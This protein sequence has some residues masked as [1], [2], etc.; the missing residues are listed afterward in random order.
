[1]PQIMIFS[2]ANDLSGGNYRLLRVLEHFPKEEY[3]F[4]MPRDRKK[5][6]LKI[7]KKHEIGE[8]IYHIVSN[9]YELKEFG[10]GDIINYIKYGFYVVE[11]AKKLGC[12]VVYFPHEHTYLPI[13]FRLGSM[14]YKVMWTELLQLTPVLGSLLKEDGSG[15]KLLAENF[16]LHGRSSLKALKGYLR[17]RAFK[18]AVGQTPILAVSRSI[19]YELNKL[20]VN[21]NVKVVEPGNA[22]D[23]CPF[24]NLDREYDVGFF[25]RVLPEKG[26]FDFI[27]AI[28]I[29]KKILPNL[30]VF[31]SGSIDNK[32]LE[33]VVNTLRSLDLSVELRFNVTQEE[34]FRLLAFTKVLLYPTRVDA[35]P[36]V[37]LEALSCGTPVVAYAIPAI[38][39]N[40]DT[41]AVLKVEPLNIRGLVQTTMHVL[42]EGLW[43]RLENE[44]L[45][46]ASRFT[47]DRVAQAEWKILTTLAKQ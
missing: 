24:R 21:A 27:K 14:R 7:I 42:K 6:M 5:N 1:M 9:A 26:I 18:Y 25:A 32:N 3:I 45:N 44:A 8:D 39:F 43:E 28:K 40:F 10:K 20:G 22:S 47:W 46:F 19:P 16:R 23:K 30:K 38:R 35:F 17:L 33:K 36:T 34:K 31:I 41:P 2:P 4:A 29:L 13:G 12:E 15:F 11:V 37:V